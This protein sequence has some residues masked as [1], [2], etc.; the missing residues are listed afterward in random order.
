MY[1]I[2]QGL[3]G[4]FRRGTAYLGFVQ[5]CGRASEDVISF[6][7]RGR[8]RRR[9]LESATRTARDA[10]SK[11]IASLDGADVA[12]APERGSVVVAVKFLQDC[13]LLI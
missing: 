11:S 2:K 9:R 1:A 6:V 5:S 12:L 3:L 13:I 8:L 7:A 4:V 10:V